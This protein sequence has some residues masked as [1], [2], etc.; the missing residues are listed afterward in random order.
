[1]I[2]GGVLFAAFLSVVPCIRNILAN[3]FKR[4][5][6]VRVFKHPDDDITEPDEEPRPLPRK[7]SLT[8]CGFSSITFLGG[9]AIVALAS[10]VLAVSRV[11]TV[12]IS[13]LGIGILILVFSVVGCCAAR[14]RARSAPSCWLLT[15]FIADIG[16]LALLLWTI[17]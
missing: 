7:P 11:F 15:Y 10:Y 2:C 1:V 4:C 6:G 8:L 14:K 12:A 5:C 17:I 9:A 16:M 3:F 13:L